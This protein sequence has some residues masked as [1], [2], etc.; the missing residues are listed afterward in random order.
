LRGRDKT[1][2]PEGNHGFAVQNL[3]AVRFR[4]DKDNLRTA[5][6]TD[7]LASQ[8]LENLPCCKQGTPVQ[9]SDY[10][11]VPVTRIRK[12]GMIIILRKQLENNAQRISSDN[13]K[14]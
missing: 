2:I 8:S 9:E 3:P 12:N 13:N 7:P 10:N 4:F 1:I 6:K 14:L 11:L 5:C